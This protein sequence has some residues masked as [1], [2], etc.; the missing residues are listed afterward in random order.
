MQRNDFY[1]DRRKER[2]IDFLADYPVVRKYFCRKFELSSQD[3]QFLCKLHSLGTFLRGDFEER[4]LIYSWDQK[5]WMRFLQ[6][7]WIIVYRERKPSAG[8]NYKIYT[9]SHKAKNMV[10]DCY[11]M[12]CGEMPIPETPRFNPIM[13]EESYSDKHYA[14]A[15]RAFNAA[16]NNK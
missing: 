1:S 4:R 8:R 2:Y 7:G 16:R 12:L 14:D 13:K 5:R 15:I 10:E 6:D 9:I 11:K 3:F